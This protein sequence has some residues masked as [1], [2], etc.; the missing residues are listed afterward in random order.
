MCFPE[1]T[2][3]PRIIE[4]MNGK[5]RSSARSL[6]W[7]ATSL[8]DCMRHPSSMPLLLD[9]AGDSVQNGNICSSTFKISMLHENSGSGNTHFSQ[10]LLEINA[11]DTW[12]PWV[13]SKGYPTV[14][15]IWVASASSLSLWLVPRAT[16]KGSLAD[17]EMLQCELCHES[18]RD[19]D[20]SRSPKGILRRRSRAGGQ[21]TGLCAKAPVKQFWAPPGPLWR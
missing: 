4:K 12:S 10:E 17:S 15:T 18:D 14:L 6:I 5:I 21:G 16:G 9:P 13:A 1:A 8:A 19:L 2:G 3:L 11:T 20:K 7:L